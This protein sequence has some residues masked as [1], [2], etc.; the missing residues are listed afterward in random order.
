[1]RAAES[2]G[3]NLYKL[4]QKEKVEVLL[5]TLSLEKACYIE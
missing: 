5:D 4:L 1:M 3:E 2:Q